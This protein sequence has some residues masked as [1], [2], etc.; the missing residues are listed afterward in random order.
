MHTRIALVACALALTALPGCIQEPST[1]AET[2]E[3]VAA[4]DPLDWKAEL[5]GSVAYRLVVDGDATTR[6]K[7]VSHSNPV[8]TSATW[9][10]FIALQTGNSST[11]MVQSNQ[12]YDAHVQVLGTVD[13]GDVVAPYTWTDP[14]T[15]EWPIEGFAGPVAITV[16][17]SQLQ[18]GGGTNFG[19]RFGCVGAF[20]IESF[21][22]GREIA[23]IGPGSASAVVSATASAVLIGPALQGSAMQGFESNAPSVRF[24]FSCSSFFARGELRTPDASVPIECDPAPDG[25]TTFYDEASGPGKYALEYHEADPFSGGSWGAL[26]GLHPIT[27]FA[28]VVDAPQGHGHACE[29]DC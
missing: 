29:S 4:P 13:T 18:A 12:M 7:L 17:T 27:S 25:D 22:G 8:P 14:L 21:E 10:N 1:I 11:W 23:I 5:E 26:M 20:T 9:S 3:N 15:V 16:G 6:C 19:I 2:L 28:E 24:V